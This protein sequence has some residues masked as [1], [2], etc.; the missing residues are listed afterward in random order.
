MD[1]WIG[2]QLGPYELQGRLGAGGMG[3]VYKA[4]HRRLGQSRAIKVLP[5]TLAHDD[6]FVQRFEREARLASELRHA[7]I[8]MIFDIAEENGTHYIVMEL[9]DGRSLHEM[10]REDGPLPLDRALGLL[11]QLGEALDFAHQ[12]GVVHRDIKPG[13]ALVS[14]S[15]HLTL[16]DFGIARAAEGTRLTEASTRIGTAEYMAPESITLGE[17]GSGTDLYAMG[18]IAYEMLTGRVP[19]TGLNSQTIMYAQIH[20]PPPPPRTLR[21][22]LTPAVERVVLRQ[23]D[24]DPVKRYRTGREFVAALQAAGADLP[25][26]EDLAGGTLPDS[27]HAPTA[28]LDAPA[29]LEER[30]RAMPGPVGAAPDARPAAVPTGV[31]TPRPGGPASGPR[32][33]PGSRPYVPPPPTP[34]VADAIVSDAPVA[35]GIHRALQASKLDGRTIY[36][37]AIGGVVLLLLLMTF[38]PTPRDPQRGD[39]SARLAFPLVAS[40]HLFG[41]DESGRDVLSRLMVGGRFLV[42]RLAVVGLLAGGVVLLI[43]RQMRARSGRPWPG[44]PALVSVV[45]IAITASVLCETAIGFLGAD[46]TLSWLWWFGQVLFGA[47]GGVGSTTWGGMLVESRD[48]SGQAPWLVLFPAVGL[49]L[50]AVGTA[51]L[52]SGIVDLLE[53]RARLAEQRQAV[54][55]AHG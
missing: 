15:D 28:W 54:P 12:R 1:T 34:T 5:T 31:V 24:K 19:F 25:L 30:T 23:L 40:G 32:S 27:A 20:T 8:V 7:N 49:I 46:R 45:T 33:M 55:D 43:R 9:L 39:F 37:L 13:N 38:L 16:V 44:I 14:T 10:I 53:H 36:K 51:L 52:G 41:G 35:S 6:T 29:N 11:T 42:F 4:V 21:T 17:S 47:P 3:V 2:Q 22:D 50:V 26:P 18:V 48:V